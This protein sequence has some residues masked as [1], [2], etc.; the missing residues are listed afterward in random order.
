MLRAA[1]NRSIC[2]LTLLAF[3]FQPSWLEAGQAITLSSHE[4]TFTKLQLPG[5]CLWDETGEEAESGDD[6]DWLFCAIPVIKPVDCDNPSLV[7]DHVVV[8]QESKSYSLQSRPLWLTNR[9][10]LL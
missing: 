1:L 9:Q 6:D 8:F 2:L 3:V 4:Q 7:D 10:L 5:N